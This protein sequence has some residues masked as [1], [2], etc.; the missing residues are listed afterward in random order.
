MQIDGVS[1]KLMAFGP[2]GFFFALMMGK[3]G[4][5][6]QLPLAIGAFGGLLGFALQIVSRKLQEAKH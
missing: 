6:A 3:N 2:M 5:L 4:H 1:R